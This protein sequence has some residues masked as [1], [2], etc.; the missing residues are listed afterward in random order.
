MSPCKPGCV[1]TF[2]TNIVKMC[3]YKCRGVGMMLRGV[4][5]Q[6]IHYIFVY[7]LICIWNSYITRLLLCYLGNG[8]ENDRRGGAEFSNPPSSSLSSL[9]LSR[10][11][12]IESERARRRKEGRNGPKRCMQRPFKFGTKSIYPYLTNRDG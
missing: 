7:N 5:I 6:V 4:I 10:K 8:N 9:S 2:Y 1:S 12:R 11:C 3:M